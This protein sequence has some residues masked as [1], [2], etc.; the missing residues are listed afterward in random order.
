MQIHEMSV[1]AVSAFIITDGTG[2]T[3]RFDHPAEGV[4][5]ET[6]MYES[7]SMRTGDFDNE[8]LNAHLKKLFK[9]GNLRVQYV[10]GGKMFGNAD[11]TEKFA[12]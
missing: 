2:L 7:C 1:E 4:W 5:E 6:L 3:H 10:R 12:A 8:G 11:I 9:M